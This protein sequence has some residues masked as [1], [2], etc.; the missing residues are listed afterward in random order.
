MINVC[1]LLNLI[2]VGIMAYVALA[3]HIER[4]VKDKRRPSAKGKRR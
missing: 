3:D 4:K 1:N 2:F